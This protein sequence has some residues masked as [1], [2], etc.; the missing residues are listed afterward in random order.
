MALGQA[1][2]FA[3]DASKAKVFAAHIFHLLEM[4]PT[5]DPYSEEG[6]KDVSVSLYCIYLKVTQH[7]Q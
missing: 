1:S 7:V 5:V 4:E 3:P 6:K 2:A